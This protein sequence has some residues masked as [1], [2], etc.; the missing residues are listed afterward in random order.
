MN[1]KKDDLS[2]LLKFL[3]TYQSRKTQGIAFQLESF[4]NTSVEVLMHRRGRFQKH[5]WH[6]SM[7]TL[8]SFGFLSSGV[9]GGNSMVVSSFPGGP[10][11][12][13]QVVD[14]YDPNADQGGAF[15]SLIDF[16]TSVSSKPRSE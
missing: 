9:I 16:K 14:T 2:A 13:A 11:S 6:T 4:K 15:N 7:I 1:S 3:V 10:T 5:I 8:A 12:N